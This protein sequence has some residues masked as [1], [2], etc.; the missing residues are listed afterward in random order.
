MSSSPNTLASD[1]V[2]VSSAA[3]AAIKQ[4]NRRTHFFGE[5]PADPAR[6]SQA[7]TNL[8]AFCPTVTNEAHAALTL[9]GLVVLAPNPIWKNASRAIKSVLDQINDKSKKRYVGGLLNDQ[10]VLEGL[11]SK[12]KRPDAGLFVGNLATGGDTD[13]LWKI[14]PSIVKPS[15]LR[16]EITQVNI[17]SILLAAVQTLSDLQIKRK[18]E[19]LSQQTFMLVR[20]AESYLAPLCEL[21]ENDG[22]AMALNSAAARARLAATGNKGYV[23]KAKAVYAGIG[24]HEI[25]EQE[26]ESAIESLCDESLHSSTVD[27]NSQHRTLIGRSLCMINGV[28]MVAKYRRKS[29]GQLARKIRRLGGKLPMDI[30]GITFVIQDSDDF[31]KIFSDIVKKADLNDRFQFS[32]TPRRNEALHIRGRDIFRSQIMQRLDNS[33]LNH[34]IQQQPDDSLELAKFT[35]LFDGIPMEIQV[36][37]KTMA[38]AMRLGLIAHIGYKVDQPITLADVLAMEEI[39]QRASEIGTGQLFGSTVDG[40]RNFMATVERNALPFIA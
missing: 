3:R 12:A 20:K 19:Y 35:A 36:V 23:D 37:T 21:I 25:F 33:G 17:E 2:D 5:S 28:E 38:R 32:P 18:G 4:F 1:G 11:W 27:Y 24:D 22:L 30:C 14:E 9:S 8:K 6:I 15:T 10:L 7:T 31:A 13:Q 40:A 29:L 16:D 26:M 39:N 34:D